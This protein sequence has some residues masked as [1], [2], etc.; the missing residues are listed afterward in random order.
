[1][2]FKPEHS[3]RRNAKIKRGNCLDKL[4]LKRTTST[5]LLKRTY[6][7]REQYNELIQ[8]ITQKLR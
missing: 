7:R 8:F 6:T 5:Q 4:V 2:H 3:R 1:M